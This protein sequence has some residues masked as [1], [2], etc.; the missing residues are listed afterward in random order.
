MPSPWPAAA[1]E[2]LAALKAAEVQE[3]QRNTQHGLP[4]RHRQQHALSRC[5]CVGGACGSCWAATRVERFKLSHH[6]DSADQHHHD[7]EA[8][9][10]CC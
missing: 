5:G 8:R 2:A 10:C 6:T 3:Q 7:H 9:R 1:V 4:R